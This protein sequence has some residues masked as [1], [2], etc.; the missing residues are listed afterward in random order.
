M[1]DRVFS[2]IVA[3]VFQYFE[4]IKKKDSRDIF[5]FL[6]GLESI[7]E[8]FSPRIVRFRFLPVFIDL[9][10]K[11][12]RFGLAVIPLLFAMESKF[13][14]DNEFIAHVLVPLKYLLAHKEIPKLAEL[15]LNHTDCLLARVPRDRR[16]EF[17]YP[18]VVTALKSSDEAVLAQVF[19]SLPYMIEA[20][21]DA[22]IKHVVTTVSGTL[23]KLSQ[24]E[25]AVSAINIFRFA[26]LRLGP[27]HVTEVAV[28]PLRQLWRKRRWNGLALAVT[29][30]ISSL[31]VD[32]DL[33][34]NTTML[35]ASEMVSHRDL[36]PLLQARLLLF[37]NRILRQCH[38]DHQLAPEIIQHA[39]EWV[40]DPISYPSG[41]YERERR[42]GEIEAEIS[43]E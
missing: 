36:D 34:L 13:D 29:D 31:D 39:A 28:R 12:A 20:M 5:N 9:I 23:E 25:L 35:L 16:P 30:L 37:M 3:G 17:V 14:D 32:V 11:D 15:Y 27:V 4:V 18:A 10:K 22:L 33:A 19:L 21:D 2:S 7:A 42:D 43:D 24:P 38:T 26:I 1:R 8:V 40:V 41:P 6:R